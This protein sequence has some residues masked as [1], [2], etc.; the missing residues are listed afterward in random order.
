M[1][2]L[3]SKYVFRVKNGK[4]KV[5]LVAMG[6][7]QLQGVDSHETYAPVIMMNTIRK[8]LALV[9]SLDLELEQM[10]VVTAFLNGDLD[11]G[12]YMDIPEGFRTQA[13]EDKV[14]KLRKSLYGLK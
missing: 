10:D 11:K 12:I 3:P 5:R 14:C 13:N 1:H 6:C 4:P 2:V 7:R 9:A 8:I